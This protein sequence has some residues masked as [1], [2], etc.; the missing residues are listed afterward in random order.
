MGLVPAFLVVDRF[1]ALAL[2]ELFLLE[3]RIAVVVLGFA[4]SRIAAHGEDSSGSCRDANP[5]ALPIAPRIAVNRRPPKEE[6]MIVY[7]S[8]LSPFVRKVLA[9]ASEKHI[10]L[11]LKPTG[12]GD[13]DLRAASPFGKM[14]ALSDGDFQLSDSSAIIH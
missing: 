2:G 5:R 10:E 7:G 9:Y 1:A 14:P 11:E 4:R 8:S 3:R 13:P 6:W 12:P